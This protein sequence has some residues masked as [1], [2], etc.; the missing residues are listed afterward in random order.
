MISNVCMF[1]IPDDWTNH[2]DC[3]TT[4][5]MSVGTHHQQMYVGSARVENTQ[6]KQNATQIFYM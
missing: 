6:N 2:L 3:K 5:L 1:D 4:I